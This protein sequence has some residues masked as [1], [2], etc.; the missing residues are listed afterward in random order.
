MYAYSNI[1]MGF[2]PIF[3]CLDVC[4]GLWR[5]V[6]IVLVE[7]RREKWVCMFVYGVY[8]SVWML[9]FYY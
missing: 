4:G 5:N 6:E 3:N 8:L 2:R 1:Y 9:I 7:K